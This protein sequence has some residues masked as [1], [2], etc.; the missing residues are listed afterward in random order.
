MTSPSSLDDQH[1]TDAA[2]TC[3]HASQ[4]RDALEK[5]ADSDDTNVTGISVRSGE[6]VGLHLQL[7]DETPGCFGDPDTQ[8]PRSLSAGELRRLLADQSLRHIELTNIGRILPHHPGLFLK[9]FTVEP[10]VRRVAPEPEFRIEGGD[11]VDGECG[12]VA[13]VRAPSQEVALARLREI[14]FDGDPHA[15]SIRLDGIELCVYMNTARLRV[16]RVEE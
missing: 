4:L 13:Y 10:T 9:Y 12:F 6:Y 2:D 16:S 14:S 11:S 8:F 5:L 1:R 3:L 7:D 15:A